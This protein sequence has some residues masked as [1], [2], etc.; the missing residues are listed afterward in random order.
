MC[1]LRATGA[2]FDP[3]A[4]LSKSTLAGATVHRAGELRLPRSQPHGPRHERSG[5]T[6]GVSDAG[7]A[8]LSSQV[9]DALNFLIANREELSRLVAF[10]GVDDV[11]LDFPCAIRADG[12]G[13]VAQCEYLPPKSGSSRSRHRAIALS[14]GRC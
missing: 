6:I 1:V 11:R 9:E 3:G 2:A 4:F 10:P 14:S 8:D 12:V 5:L 13:V 7:W